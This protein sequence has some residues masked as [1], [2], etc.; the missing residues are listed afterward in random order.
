MKT[1]TQLELDKMTGEDIANVLQIYP[2]LVDQVDVD[3]MS[4]DD[5]AFLIKNQPRF[6]HLIDKEVNYCEWGAFIQYQ[7][8]D[9]VE[10]RGNNYVYYYH[11]IAKLYES[12]VGREPNAD[13]LHWLEI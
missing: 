2:E 12:S 4:N 5:L 6:K 8:G 11:P 9:L 7:P 13:S 1:Y 10:Y 3:K